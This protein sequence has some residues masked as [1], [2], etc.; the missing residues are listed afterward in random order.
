MGGSACVF[1]FYIYNLI[2]VS[3]RSERTATLILLFAKQSPLFIAKFVASHVC[4]LGVWYGGWP[5]VFRSCASISS[6]HTCRKSK[7]TCPVPEVKVHVG[8]YGDRDR[9]GSGTEHVLRR[10]LY[11]QNGGRVV[12]ELDP[13]SRLDLWNSSLTLCSVTN[14]TQTKLVEFVRKPDLGFLKDFYLQT[15]ARNSTHPTVHHYNTCTTQSDNH[16]RGRT[17]HTDT[18]AVC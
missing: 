8:C 2:A 7:F 12:A 4:M 15:S 13:T 1:F 6:S 3:E 9:K 10:L 5:G 16:D 18:V 11:I 14:K 17:F